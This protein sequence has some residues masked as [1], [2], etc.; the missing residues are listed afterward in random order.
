MSY[1]QK[2]PRLLEEVGDLSLSVFATQI[3]LLYIYLDASTYGIQIFHR[4][5]SYTP[6]LILKEPDF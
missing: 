3:G 1:E 2:D 6:L 5:A 4:D